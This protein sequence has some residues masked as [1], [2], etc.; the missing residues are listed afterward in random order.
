MK[1]FVYIL[2]IV[3]LLPNISIAEIVNKINII[4]NKRISDETIKVYGDVK[5][6]G[7][8]YTKSDLDNILKNLYSTNFFETVS[9]EIIKNILN[10][11]LKEYPVINQLVI[12]G[13]DSSRITKELKKNI[14]SKEK[15]SYVANNLNNDLNIIRQL[16]SSLGYNFP[17][18]DTKIK[19]INDN[20]LDLIINIKKGKITKISKISFSGDK[21]IREK[22]LRD[23]IASEE[24]KFWK[25]LSRNSRFSENLI[26]LDKRL[27]KNYYKSLGYYDVFIT[28]SSAEIQDSESVNIN[29]SIN[30]GNRYIIKK[31]STNVD[32]V[33]DKKLFFP[34]NKTYKELTG[35]YYSP[36]KVK[37]ILDEIDNLIEKNNL[38]FV[39]H[40][41]QEVIEGDNIVLSFNIIEGE[42]VLVERINILGNNVT[43]ESVI[44]SEL[45][46]DEGDPFTN[47]TLDKSVAK[48]KSR[49]IFQT[50]TSEVKSGSSN[51]LKIINLKV[52]EKPTGEISAGAGV[53]TNGGSFAFNI[54]ENNWLGEGKNI[55]LD[56]EISEESLKGQFIYVDPNYDLLGNKLKYHV[57]NTSNDKPDQGYENSLVSAGIETT[58]E[59]YKDIYTNVGINLLYDDLRTQAN[60]SS[61]LKKQ[62]GEFLELSG[63]YGF[64]S[65]KRDR[66][67]NP[68]SGSIVSFT[69][70]LPFYAD[71]PFIDNT[72]TLSNYKSLS[73]DVIGAGKFYLS[74]I[75]G[76]DNEDVRISKRKFLST[77]RL[78]GF[79]KG[80]VG[81]IDEKDHIGGNYAA[82]LNLEASLPNFLP[83]STNTDVGFFL[84]FGNVWG[85]DYDTT[86]ADSNKLRSATG[87]AASWLSPLGPM[88]FILSTDLAKA[89]T[90]ETESFHFNLGATF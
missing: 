20:N 59:Q 31:I 69:Q 71:K 61:S 57:A 28:S 56:F 43:N 75:N 66:V 40:Q 39:E 17:K 64:T 65:D 80:K 81:P 12:I 9:V 5:K 30:A 83:E 86:I 2:L 72:L 89:D 70:T 23:I 1:K 44:R 60:A 21:K 55:G 24:D 53:G 76:L 29:Y 42:K 16:Y 62:S 54:R 18:I 15:G 6:I 19:I 58:F 11:N 51:D 38:Q 36:F 67:F 8:D 14:K 37:K 27:L 3:F 26:N 7:A 74:A 4:G 34:L 45:L 68:T 47:I 50:V 35:D 84:D 22:R 10:I 85:V 88:T 82:V 77:S 87:V 32:S 46:L 41:V 49:N 33:F 25:F 90:D 13:E 63:V 79:K 52:E 48:I 73:E 78:R